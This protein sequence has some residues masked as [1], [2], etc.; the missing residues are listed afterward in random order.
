MPAGVPV[1]ITSPGSSVITCAIQRIITSTE[2]IISDDAGGLFPN[3]VDVGLD[4][5]IGRIEVRLQYRAEGAEGVE[6]F[7]AG[8]LAVEFLQVARGD[9]VEASVAERCRAARLRRGPGETAAADDDGELAFVVDALGDA[10]EDDRFFRR[11]DR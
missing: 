1:A 2:K 7:A 11:D 10:R 9:V 8:P 4:A 6:A 5:G 3:A